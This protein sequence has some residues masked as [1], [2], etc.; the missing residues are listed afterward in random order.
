M[1]TQK[2]IFLGSVSMLLLAGCSSNTIS[3]YDLDKITRERDSLLEVSNRNDSS[4][5]AFL[6]SFNDIER[7]L[8]NIKA[9]QEKVTLRWSGDNE[10]K[11]NT[12]EEIMEDIRII[13]EMIEEN[14]RKISSLNGIIKGN[15]DKIQELNSTV[16][17][18][19]Q[20]IKDKNQELTILNKSLSEKNN[21]L[22]KRNKII[23][24]VPK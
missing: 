16:N 24:Q 22:S 18:L 1:K 7:N 11:R 6:I 15:D 21:E 4:I 10:L 3:Q 19:I 17:L 12:Q 8:S 2:F 23:F 9:K 13:N 20:H 14:H 5:N